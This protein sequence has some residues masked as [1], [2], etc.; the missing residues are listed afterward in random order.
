MLG[1]VDL[2]E[3]LVPVLAPAL[4]RGDRAF[5]DLQQRLL[6]A[7]VGDQVLVLAA[8]LIDLVDVMMPCW[9]FSIAAGGLRS[10][11]MFSTSSPT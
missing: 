9:H 2:E 3:L 11:L 6:D 4:Q 1:G 8:D 7:H 5:E 10:E